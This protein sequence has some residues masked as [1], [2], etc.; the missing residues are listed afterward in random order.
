M[1]QIIDMIGIE[2]FVIITSCV[3]FFLIVY[4]K[5]DAVS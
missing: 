3:V 1:K 2:I 5:V 4:E